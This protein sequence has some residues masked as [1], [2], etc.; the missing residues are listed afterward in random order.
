MQIDPKCNFLLR[1]HGPSILWVWFPV[2][3]IWSQFCIEKSCWEYE[4]CPLSGIKNH[5]LLG[6]WFSI[7]TIIIMLISIRN[8]EI[9]H[10]REV[11]H[12]SEGPLSEARLY[13][14]LSVIIIIIIKM[15][16]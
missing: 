15:D 12:S 13:F 5:A 14:L 11:V 3:T 4:L 10:C 8:T 6:G 16:N 7:T 9:V 2:S 1:G